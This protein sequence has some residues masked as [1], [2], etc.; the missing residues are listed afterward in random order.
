MLCAKYYAMCF[1][2]AILNLILKGAQDII[3]AILILLSRKSTNH[4]SQSKQVHLGAS[5]G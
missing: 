2:Y 4:G 3:N 1:S 5:V